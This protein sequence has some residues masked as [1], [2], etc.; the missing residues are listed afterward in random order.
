MIVKHGRPLRRRSSTSD[1]SHCSPSTANLISRKAASVLSCIASL[2]CTNFSR[3]SDI[4]SSLPGFSLSSLSYS[5]IYALVRIFLTIYANILTMSRHPR[6]LPGKRPR[7]WCSR[8]R[9]RLQFAGDYG[10][11]SESVRPM[12]CPVMIRA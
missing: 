11:E 3:A 9:F 5:A 1:C 10:H 7:F 12:R 2:A 4:K 6:Y 8:F